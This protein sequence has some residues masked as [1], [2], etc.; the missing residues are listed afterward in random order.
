M[1]AGHYCF[2]PEAALSRIAAGLHFLACAN[3]G[4]FLMTA[5]TEAYLGTNR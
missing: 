1:P 3:E 5:A 4:R 2:N